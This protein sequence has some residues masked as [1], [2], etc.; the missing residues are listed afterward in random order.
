MN[1]LSTYDDQT[2]QK[3][4]MRSSCEK[5]FSWKKEMINRQVAQHSEEYS[6][7]YWQTH[8]SNDN[9]RQSQAETGADSCKE[10]TEEKSAK[11]SSCEKG[12]SSTEESIDT[13]HSPVYFITYLLE[14]TKKISFKCMYCRREYLNEQSWMTHSETHKKGPLKCE[15][16][17]YRYTR[18][19]SLSTHLRNIHNIEKPYDCSHCEKKFAR[20][21]QLTAHLRRLEIRSGFHKKI[22][23]C[24]PCGKKYYSVECWEKHLQSQAHTKE[25]PFECSKCDRLFSR[26]GYLRVH[27]YTH[28]NG[29]C[30]SKRKELIHQTKNTD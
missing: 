24:P 25:K 10:Q 14:D 8:L 17:E 16:C 2:A 19:T 21:R 5:G 12:F 15:L 28:T 3:S 1:M 26:K 9:T 6:M 13:Q 18:K 29:K 4:F 11:F 23:E 20:R 30:N 27:S 7:R 22:F